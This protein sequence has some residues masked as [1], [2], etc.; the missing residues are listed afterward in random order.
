MAMVL[1]GLDSVN[2]HLLVLA[3]NPSAA[4]ISW[5]SFTYVGPRR[6]QLFAVAYIATPSDFAY[7][8]VGQ[9]ALTEESPSET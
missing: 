2:I 3:E 5:A 8:D 4:D 9:R 1:L 6:S 7:Q